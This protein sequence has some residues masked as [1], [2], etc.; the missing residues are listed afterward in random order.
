MK[1]VGVRVDEEVA[2]SDS[3]V[4]YEVFNC[5]LEVGRV[6]INGKGVR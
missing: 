5:R 4:R 3:D 6:E 1:G 2:G